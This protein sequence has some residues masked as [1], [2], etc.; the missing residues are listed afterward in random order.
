M[1]RI[2][3]LALIVYPFDP[4]SHFES[5]AHTPSGHASTLTL[6]RSPRGLYRV[7]TTGQ[8][9][10]H[11]ARGAR[12]IGGARGARRERLMRVPQREPGVIVDQR[13][14]ELSLIHISEPT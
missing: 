5:S 12:G 4:E 2:R 9:V 1:G 14:L 3:P 6:A 13:H 7:C 8:H 11:R 10:Q